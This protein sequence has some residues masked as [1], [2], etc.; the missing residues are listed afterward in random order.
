LFPE[1]EPLLSSPEPSEQ[2]NASDVYNREA[3]SGPDALSAAPSAQLAE[4]G[5]IWKTRPGV[6]Y[7]SFMSFNTEMARCIHHNPTLKKS[8]AG[9]TSVIAKGI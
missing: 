2:H 9:E 8:S 5:D 4:T 6:H 1:K 3:H 7:R